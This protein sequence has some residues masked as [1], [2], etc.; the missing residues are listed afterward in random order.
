[1]EDVN[2]QTEKNL[3]IIEMSQKY[4]WTFLGEPW[5]PVFDLNDVMNNWQTKMLLF[6]NKMEAV[7]LQRGKNLFIIEKSRKYKWTFFGEPWIPVDF[8]MND[9]QPNVSVNFLKKNIFFRLLLYV[10]YLIKFFS[11]RKKKTANH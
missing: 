6:S 5:I 11:R 7:N 2:L 4:G 10:I 9:W 3:S 8:V 1:M